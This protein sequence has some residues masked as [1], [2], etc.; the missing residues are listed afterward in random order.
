MRDQFQECCECLLLGLE[1]VNGFLFLLIERFE[2]LYLLQLLLK[3]CYA[4]TTRLRQ[5]PVV[6]VVSDDHV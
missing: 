4:T 2:G 6:L 1:L 3:L 5:L